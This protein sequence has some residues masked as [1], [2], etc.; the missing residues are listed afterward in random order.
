MGEAR[1]VEL[2]R[3]HPAA[4]VLKLANHPYSFIDHNT[5]S[6]LHSSLVGAV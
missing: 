6:P 1:L 5:Q 4:P 3:E 2:I